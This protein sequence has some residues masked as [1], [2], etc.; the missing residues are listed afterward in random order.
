MANILDQQ[1]TQVNITLVPKSP[2]NRVSGDALEVKIKEIYGDSSKPVI[3][4]FPDIFVLFDPNNQVAV[5]VLSEQ[6]RIII[7]DNRVTPYA[8]R[9]MRKF[10]QFAK[11]S[12]DIIL[13]ETQTDGI[14]AYG[15]NILATIDVDQEDS[16][17][18]LLEKFIKMEG[19]GIEPI[20]GGIRLIF[21]VANGDNGYRCDLRLDP[22]FGSKLTPTKSI[23]VNQNSHFEV[24]SLPTFE[25]LS[26]LV[27]KIYNGLPIFLA[28]I[29]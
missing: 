24:V 26:D 27:I 13:K 18:F 15:L 23:Q 21:K 2:I 4:K 28:K 5:N 9:D 7:S 14:V 3:T 1:T 17:K 8:S 20:G 12:A 25:E 19:N 16:S 29:L 6:N 10:V 22:R 11:S